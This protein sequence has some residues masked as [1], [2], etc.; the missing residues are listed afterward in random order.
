MPRKK[1]AVIERDDTLE[2]LKETLL[3]EVVEELDQETPVPITTESVPKRYIANIYWEKEPYAKDIYAGSYVYWDSTHGV[4]LEE[5]N[6]K[7]STDL[8]LLS[9]G[10]I[11]VT[12]EGRNYLI[13]RWETPKDWVVNLPFASLG[14]RYICKDVVELYETE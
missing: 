4:T 3:A 5:L 7:Y 10:D 14:Q 13:S 9:K 1:Q 6:P 8:E 2:E 11:L 12:K